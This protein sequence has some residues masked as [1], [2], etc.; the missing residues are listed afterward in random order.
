MG[1]IGIADAVVYFYVKE[2]S[3]YIIHILIF[4]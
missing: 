4:L 2:G 1:T 3:F